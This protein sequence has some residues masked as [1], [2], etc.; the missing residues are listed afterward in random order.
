MMLN[1]I[2]TKIKNNFSYY[3]EI[4]KEKYIIN[5]GLTKNNT[6]KIIIRV[7]DFPH[8]TKKIDDFIKFDNIMKKYRITYILG[9]TP[10][11][12]IQPHIPNS[13]D[14][15]KL[16]KKEIKILKNGIKEN[17]IILAMHGLTHK[18]TSY[19][20]YSE[21]INKPNKE[22]ER[23]IEFGFKLFKEYGLP[24]PT[25]LIPPYNSFNKDNLEIF[26]NYFK[27]I[28]GG[29][30]TI[31]EFGKIHLLKGINY[32]PSYYPNYLKKNNIVKYKPQSN[33]NCIT[34]H[35]AWFNEEELNKLFYKIKPYILNYKEYVDKGLV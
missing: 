22:I 28:T 21:Y 27:I 19:K 15:R 11:L 26:K 32:I 14:F 3:W 4:L 24:K 5:L 16:N 25:I 9:V 33:L 1:N 18:T 31:K 12:A 6:P 2:L 20:K 29:P 10:Y 23:E 8:W 34:I 13:K 35:W 30:E 17:R 7:D